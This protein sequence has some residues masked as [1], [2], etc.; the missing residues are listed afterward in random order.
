MHILEP[1]SESV[2]C[3]VEGFIILLL[4]TL[5]NNKKD[6]ITRNRMK[7]GVFIVLYTLF[8]YWA[9]SYMPVGIHTLFITIFMIIVLTFITKS[10]LYASVI[11]VAIIFIIFFA[12]EAIFWIMGMAVLK[13]G[14]SEM[15]N[16]PKLKFVHSTIVK[17]LQLGVAI[18]LFRLNINI[19]K[20]NIFKKENS[21][22]SFVI[23]QMSIMGAFIFSLNYVVS[24][25]TDIVLYNVLLFA[26]YILFIFLA[27]LDFRERERI[28]RLQHKL[29]A[30][31][32]YVE[33]METVMNILRREK[34]DFA[35]HLNTIFAMSMLGKPDTTDKIQ[36]YIKKLT[37]NLTSSYQFFDTGNDF[38]DGLLAVKSNFA[39]EHDIHLEV[40]I[41]EPFGSVLVN[42]SDLTS[43]MGN[44][45]DNA[46]EAIMEQG[47]KEGKV[48]SICTFL[49]DKDYY[50]SISDNGPMIPREN[51][52]KIFENG[53]S[54][55][56][57]GAKEHGFGLYIVKQL[58]K[59]NHGEITVKSSQQETEFLIKFRA[60]GCKDDEQSSSSHY[61]GHTQGKAQSHGLAN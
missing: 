25:Q 41:E 48:V 5:I 29:E 33:N 11:S 45:I 31:E 21:L 54:T 6:F 40:D 23:L 46:F 10:N 14:L 59:K 9:S 1:I 2:F 52:D 3:F 43:I 39:F 37:D 17:V 12:I 16:F 4:F 47:D 56:T 42:D 18:F 50:L 58:V 22:L 30:Q 20:L 49:E 36:M 51:M 26:I 15:L 7:A 57:I 38:V 60:R 27:Y 53:F 28:L 19:F 8:S 32:E 44:I 13:V 35:N 55:K 24:H 34:H 61:Q